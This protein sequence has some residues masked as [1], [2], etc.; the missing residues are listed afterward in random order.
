MITLYPGCLIERRYPGFEKSAISVLK[1][2][3]IEFVESFEFTCCPDPIWVKS[4]DEDTWFKIASRNI[5]IAEKEGN[6]LVTLCNGCFESLNTI[7]KILKKDE[8]K[9]SLANGFLKEYGLNFQGKIEVYHLLNYLYKEIGIEKIKE[10]IKNPLEGLN[11]AVHPGCHFSRPSEFA[12]TDDPL[13]PKILEEM[14]K[15]LGAEVFE[16]DGK[17]ECCG[18][19]N[20]ITD[21]EISLK[22]AENKINRV[23]ESDGIVVICPSCF[24]Q[25]ENAQILSKREN[26]VP[27]FYYLELLALAM[28]ENLENIG[29]NFHKI[30]VFNVLKKKERVG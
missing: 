17:T 20:F 21:K 13:N 2:L 19:P 24:M 1:N 15:V 11:L 6:P 9:K 8:K 26:K 14:V 4:Y 12:Q 29:F 3:D 5:S 25:F 23:S 30:E 22:I 10:K 18:L 27:I 7:N 16:Y 28:G